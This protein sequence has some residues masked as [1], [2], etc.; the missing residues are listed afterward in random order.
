MKRFFSFLLFTIFSITC[1][2]QIFSWVGFSPIFDLQSDT[3][4]ISISGLPNVIDT[5]FGISHVCLDITHT[6]DN[7]LIIKLYSPNNDSVTLIQGIGGANNNFLNTCL[8]Q[9]GTSFSNASAPYSGIFVPIGDLSAMNNNQNPN[10]VWKL[11]VRDNANDDTGSVHQVILEFTNNPPQFI[12]SGGG[13]TGIYVCPSCVCPGG[14]AGCD[15]LPDMTSSAKEIQ[16]NH[17]ETPGQIVIS[18]A[19]PNIGA[20]PLEIFGIDSCY[21]GNT[22]VPCNTICPGN[23]DIKHVI[24]QRIY[25]KV[26]GND[27]LSYYDKFAGK[28]T[29]HETHGHLH[30]DSFVSFTLRTATS[31]PDAT[32]WPIVA[33]GTKQ[34]FCLINIGT[35]AGNYGQCLDA[36]NNVVTTVLNQGLG[37]HSGCGLTQGIYAGS[38]DVY[39]IG[40]NEPIPLNNVCN[41]NYYIVSITDPLNNFLES[42]ETNN[43]V[44]VPITLTQQSPTPSITPNGP[45]QFCLGDSVV[46]NSSIAPNY[47]W[48]TGDTTQSIVVYGAGTYSVSSNCGTSTTT[49]PSITTSIINPSSQASVSIAISSGSNPTCSGVSVTFTASP[50]NGGANPS[51]QWKVDGVNTGNNSAVFTSTFTNPTQVVTCEMTSSSTCIAN[52]VTISNAIT[53][54]IGTCYCPPIWGTTSNSGCLD[55]DLIAQV[56][57]NT[58]NNASGSACP[59]GINGYADYSTSSNPTHTT[60]LQAGN[61]YTLTVTA[62]QYSEGYKAWIDYDNNGVFDVSDE[63]GFTNIVAGSGTVG[64]NGQS[65]SIIFTIPCSVTS[66][67]H[68]LRIRCSYNNTGAN[69]VPCA[70]MNNYGEAEDYTINII[71]SLNCVAPNSLAANTITTNSAELSWLPG[72][73]ENNWHVHVTP[74]GFGPPNVGNGSNPNVTSPLTI[75]GLKSNFDYEFWVA[76]DCTNSNNGISSWAGPFPFST[77][78]NCNILP[79]ISIANP[80][81]IGELPCFQLPYSQTLIND[82]IHCFS[83]SYTGNSNQTSADVW[84]SFT[85]TYADTIQLSHCASTFDTYLHLLNSNG[86]PLVSNDDNGPLCSGTRASIETALAPG[87]YYIVSEGYGN[88]SGSITLQV[89]KKTNC[90]ILDVN[91]LLEGYYT[92]NGLLQKVLYNQGM[93]PNPN[94]NFVDTV[95]VSLHEAFFPYA[96]V[97]TCKSLLKTDGSI[98]CQFPLSTIGVN[99]YIVVDHR[100]TIETWSSQPITM[101]NTNM[102][103]FRLNANTAYGNNQVQVNSSPDFFAFYTGD[104]NQDGNIDIFDFLDLDIDNQNFV[105]AYAST[106]FNGDG[107]VDVFDFLLWDPNNQS[108]ISTIAP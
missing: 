3:I 36:N 55:G 103:D 102:Y 34:S 19:T 66:G 33:S 49:S 24:K 47:L 83:N 77:L 12:P 87:T 90:A 9:D 107:F 68:R 67:A 81:Q 106:D 23:D 6:Y 99:Y 41:G 8:G 18:N 11:V 58:L 89:N 93:D 28:M 101:A 85:L 53:M 59:S 39:G 76:A 75:N 45:L 108:F 16:F 37:F 5:S 94:S 20:G 105:S 26:P 52:P 74:N 4:N 30:V 92:N 97:H 1:Q 64:V 10:G 78:V 51:Y 32:T 61:T 43:W 50:I 57:L 86:T 35:C 70:F 44:A 29:Y 96:A 104:N 82:S 15:L 56:V 25:Q 46:L 72:C 71:P 69:I 79:G 84:H 63:I 42:D 17:V 73:T 14:A 38:Y 48:S 40:L 91:C 60:S 31:N 22:P 62:G 95:S 54:N 13:P 27:T 2:A 80:I 88:A 21:C 100:N 7:D 65:A 98:Q